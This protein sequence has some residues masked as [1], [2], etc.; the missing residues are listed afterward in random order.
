MVP[1]R[2]IAFDARGVVIDGRDGVGLQSKQGTVGALRM[3]F[4]GA[5]AVAPEGVGA[6]PARYH[7]LVGASAAAWQTDVRSYAGLAYRQ[8]WPGVDAVFLG[9]AGGLKYQ[10]ELAAGA[11]PSRVAWLVEGA[12]GADIAADGS[13]VWRVGGQ[14]M[15]DAAPLVFQPGVGGQG[16]GQVTVTSAY[17]LEALGGQRWRV[18]FRLG[19]YD[20]ARPLVIDPAWTGYSGL[21]GG[22]YDDLVYAVARD[23]DGN[24]YA[25]GVTQSTDLPVTTGG[26]ARGGT[27]A[28]VVKFN[29]SGAMQ[30]VTYVGGSGDDACHGLALDGLGQIYLAGGTTSN[31]FPAVG[32]DAASRFRRAKT[33]DHKD[34][35]VMRLSND[36]ASVGYA[37]YIGGAEDDQAN[38]IAVDA[39][40]RAY[41]TGYSVCTT[42]SASGC[43]TAAPQLPAHVGPRTSHGGD[44]QGLGG[45]D[46]FV[47]RVSANGSTL[48]YAGFLGGDGGD[49]V[50]HAVAVRADGTAIVVGATSSSAASLPTLTGFRTVTNPDRAADLLD[51]F[52]AT[53][54]ESGGSVTM[55][56]LAGGGIDRALA[57]ALPADGS[58]VVG[59]ETSSAG[60]PA[61][62]AGTRA[63]GNGPYASHSGGMDGFVVR[64]GGTLPYATYLGGSGY[65]A[66]QGVALD[67]GAVYI[68]G[69]TASG[70]GFPVQAQSGVTTTPRG[71]DDGFIVRLTH[72]TASAPAQM[73]Y[74]G[75]L[76][77]ASQDGMWAV[78]ASAVGA[79]T[80][81]SV[82][83][84][85][86]TGSSNGLTAPTTGALSAGALRSNGLVLRIDPFGPPAALTVQSGSGQSAAIGTAFGQ[87]LSVKVTDQDGRELPGVVVNFSVP[88]SGASATLSPSTSATTDAAG[89]ASVNA[90]ATMVAGS[91]NVTASA[92]G[93]TAT[94]S[95]TNSQGAQAALSVAATPASLVYGGQATLSITGGTGTGAVSYAVTAG[96][97]FCSVSGST[98]TGTGVGT[99]TVTA[100]KASDGNYQ[101]A[102]ATVDVSVGK[103]AQAGITVSANPASVVLNG[104][105]S[106][107]TTGGSTPGA[108]SYVVTDGA[109]SCS[110]SG[111]TLTALAIGTC[112]V[113]ATKAG[114][115][116]YDAVTGTVAVTVTRAS[117]GALTLSASPAASVQVNGSATLSTTGGSGT[118][119][120]GYALT[121]GASFCSLNGAVVTGVSP[122]TCTVTAT[123]AADADYEAATATLDINVGKADQATLAVAASPSTI[124]YLGTSTLSVS[125]GSGT[126]AV[127]YSVT[128]GASQCQVAGNTVTGIGIGSCTVTATKA[129]DTLYNV[130]TATVDLTVTKAAQPALNL[131]SNPASLQLLQTATLSVTGGAGT[132]VV[133]YSV[134]QGGTVC[135]VTGSTVRGD[136]LGTCEITATKAGD[137]LY[138]D[139]S[140][141]LTLSVG[142]I[143][144]TI[145][146]AALPTRV[147]GD[148][149][150]TVSATATSGLPVSFASATPAVCSVTGT[151]VRLL[152]VGTCRVTATQAGDA[153]Y[154]VAAAVPQDFS[155]TAPA[156]V[157]S[158]ITGNTPGG[159][160]TAAIAGAWQFTA[161]GAGL[162]Q[163]AGFIAMAGHPKSP[164]AAPAGWTF[165][166]GVFDFVATGGPV[167]GSVSIT[168]TFPQPVPA[169]ARFWKYGPT[170]DNTTPHWYPFNA[171]VVAGNTVTITIVD[172]GLGDDDLLANGIV[173]DAGGIGVPAPTDAAGI[174]VMDPWGLGMLSAL[175]GLWGLRR[176]RRARS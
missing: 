71:L 90:T 69:Q 58:V 175:L 33:G 15:V 47:A 40:G 31:N 121:A 153:T 122:G 51:A 52:V 62:N 29:A 20:P 24:T 137:A 89:V 112:T 25:C 151:T 115:A 46:P 133:L 99:C 22:N 92:A 53:V 105:S 162:Y 118:G 63:L 91:Y 39:L 84:F 34:A 123:K 114:D 43:T 156:G 50:G 26:A 5:A 9:H 103:A 36:G 38:G 32:T 74:G 7:W 126:G 166:Y 164:G 41:V 12:E 49:E 82:G 3:R 138:L 72:R 54:P 171:A 85:T 87:P 136:T 141:T 79:D 65:D 142:K 143:A 160:V 59:G 98:L 19:A 172:G 111:A 64:L 109:T 78:A 108:V 76:G 55:E 94:F 61:D 128:A 70:A 169:G 66:V 21:V 173:R 149:D 155:V 147:L 107:T 56:L 10:F 60:F 168:F 96:A 77:T 176:S 170:A 95:L 154:A 1:G 139:A 44:V 6:S 67:A 45:M 135:S 150:F 120:V 93:L 106:L 102:T 163:S 11:D 145:T 17:R 125:G 68:V 110:V 152:G 2:Q 100:T 148:A 80:I 28:F 73:A 124:A 104:T 117:Q 174:P 144:Q 134:T 18:G 129:A 75:F 16:Q 116:N 131:T 86:S 159:S 157:G 140:T 57:V 83:G 88:G 8:L 42:S 161:P 4:E 48:E 127:S 130:A 158:T 30:F 146:F 167:G 132:G 13:L 97:S 27:D 35:F 101:A 37:G 23:G 119:A 113:T 165:P 81:L 14:R